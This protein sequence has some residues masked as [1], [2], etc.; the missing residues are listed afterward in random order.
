MKIKV[1]LTYVM[2][3]ALLLLALVTSSVLVWRLFFLWLLVLIL[4]FL[5]VLLGINGLNVRN[6]DIGM[7]LHAGDIVSQ[8]INIYNYH[9]FPKMLLE[10]VD[11]GNLTDNQ[12][13]HVF[14]I[15]IHGTHLWERELSLRRRGRYQI[16]PFTVRT[17][18]PFDIIARERYY[19]KAGVVTVSPEV[20]PDIA[21][22]VASARFDGAQIAK[23]SDGESFGTDLSGVREYQNG[24]SLRRIHWP[25]TARQ[26]KLMVKLFQSEAEKPALSAT[27]NTLT[28]SGAENVWLVPDLSVSVQ[29]GTGN[30]GTLESTIV[31]AASLVQKY[32]EQPL[33]LIAQGK[34]DYQ[35]L[36]SLGKEH[37]KRLMQALAVMQPGDNSGISQLIDRKASVFSQGDLIIPITANPEGLLQ[38]LLKLSQQNINPVVVLLDPLSFGGGVSISAP[39]EEI[40]NAGIT[41]YLAQRLSDNSDEQSSIAAS[42]SISKLSGG[43]RDTQ[44][45]LAQD[46]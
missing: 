4:A 29:F 40:I 10:L 42:L 13:W 33:A 37:G 39:A 34:Q 21:I 1:L 25:T 26:G 6:E 14:N 9:P 7:D 24:D 30:S 5:W 15:G 18:D 23:R 43:T 16:G 22:D 17:S 8:R 12:Q 11:A 38:V 46:V 27:L 3:V 2:P 19:G 31:L 20:I 41:V 35:F 36:P 28:L 32:R 45:V 44:L